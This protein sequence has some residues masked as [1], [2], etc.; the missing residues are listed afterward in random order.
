MTLSNVAVSWVSLKGDGLPFY[1]KAKNVA[2]AKAAPDVAGDV[3]TWTAI[4][5]D[6]KLIPSFFVGGR[7]DYGPAPDGP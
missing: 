2:T 6:T 5:A 3:W 4:D 7:D 1:A